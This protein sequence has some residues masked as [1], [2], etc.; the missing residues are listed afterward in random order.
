MRTFLTLLICSFC[1]MSFAQNAQRPVKPADLVQSYQTKSTAF[2]SV[3]P[4][5]L[6]A[7]KKALV[8]EL[9]QDVV[10]YD[11]LNVN[12]ATLQGVTGKAPEAMTL[13]IPSE[14]KS[15]TYELDLVRIDL[16]TPDFQVTLASNGM[17]ANVKQGVHYRGIIK[18]DQ[19]SIAAI[20]IFDNE[21]IGLISSD[22]GNLVIG[23]L[24]NAGWNGEHILYDDKE[25][26][27]EIPFDCSMPD[28]GIGYKP[29]HLEFDESK[30]EDDCIRLYIEVDK[31]IHDGK[32][33]VTGATNFITGLMNQVITLYA[34]ESIGA[35]ISEI[36][37]WNVTSPYSSN[38][39][40]GMLSDF[41][42][43]TGAFNGD[44]AELFSYQASGGIAAGFTGICNA[45]PD[46]SKCFSSIDATYSTVPTYSWS[47]MVATHEL[48]HLWGSRHTHACVWNGNNTA[49]DGCAGGTEGSCSL[50]GNPPGGGTIMSYCHLQSVGINFNNGFG[51]QPGNVIRNSVANATC[52]VPCGT[53][54]PTCT[55]GIQNGSE[56]G[57]DCGGTCPP[58][59]CNGENVTLTII[60]DNYPGETTWSITSGSLTY[61][62]GGPYSGAGST[63]VEVICLDDGCYDFNIFDSYGDGICCGYGNGSY[64]LEN[65]SGGTLAS[66][67]NFTSSE[68]T[69]FCVGGGG[70]ILGCTDP[71]AHNYDPN[72]TQD[73]G[74]CETCTDGVQN[75]DETDVDCG[76]VLCDAC[77]TCSDGV[78]NGDETGVDCGGSC[79]PCDPGGCTPGSETFS[80]E[81]GWEG[82]SDGG[83]DCA[84]VSSSSLSW[85]GQYSIRIRDN[86]GVASSTTSPAYDLSQYSSVEVEFYFYPNSMEN[87]EDFWVRL[88]NGSGWTTIASY[89]SGSSFNNGGFYVAT[90]TVPASSLSSNCQFRFQCDASGNQDQ[91]YLDLITIRGL[92]S[93]L[94]E[95][96]EPT[97]TIAE[98]KTPNRFLGLDE[99][100]G[101]LSSFDVRVYPNPAKSELNLDIP[102]NMNIRAVKIYSIDGALSKDAQSLDNFETIDI[103]L[104]NSGIYILS[105]E[106]DNEV[107][108]KKFIKQ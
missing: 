38:S 53:P 90:V 11:V 40:S 95:S 74:S 56:T 9:D 27:S 26:L 7:Q 71:S 29:G 16:F 101:E 14:S 63:V 65:A 104:L 47:V 67:G 73:D 102:E 28:D 18:G 70:P 87:G 77:P 30:A 82:W 69:N 36:K 33:G 97:Q 13:S 55:D 3:S 49:I 25:V 43:A 1:L 59:P 108:N 42:A 37:V 105:I 60:L 79:P 20:S 78:Q 19:T 24:E 75:G 17:P 94:I 98:V 84:R 80:F 58:C 21:V 64:V 106:T 41:Q 35:E 51:P 34:N 44:L 32:G 99:M 50:P 8:T 23:K 62:S 93:G 2:E 88:N 76:G 48:G 57:V 72:A 103:S 96:G 46:E 12:V 86:S 6:A 100:N 4:F 83:S 54:P 52:T 22:A 31:D 91:I 39:S 15:V 81:T 107:I 45:D 5:S 68:T 92:C 66:G 10:D 85:D 61:A 89:A